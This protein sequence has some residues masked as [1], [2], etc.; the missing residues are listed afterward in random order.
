MKEF[1]L[2]LCVYN[3]W[4]NDSLIQCLRSQDIFDEPVM[5]LLSHIILSENF[6]MAR[7]KTEDTSNKNFWKLLNISE[8]YRT[9]HENSKAYSDY[10]KE[11]SDIDYERSVTYKNTQ[12]VEY[13]NSIEDI[14]TH[15]FFHSSYHRA[16]A[17]KEIKKLDKE[18]VY[19]DYIHYVR[20]IKSL[21]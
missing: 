2:K 18:P 8:C 11:K 9:A 7:L 16:Q 21:R 12:G 13:T 6:W 1:M 5:K 19:M 3:T 20:E 14:L 15:V 4:A 17:V 10:I